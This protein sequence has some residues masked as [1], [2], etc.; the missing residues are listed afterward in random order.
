LQAREVTP[1]FDEVASFIRLRLRR[2]ALLVFLTSLDDPVLAESFVRNMDMLC[3][4][5]LIL[6]NMLKP[7]FANP[8]FSQG[9]VTSVDEV[10]LQLAGHLQWNN[11]REMEKVLGRRGVQFALVNNEKLCVELVSQYLNVKQRQ[12]L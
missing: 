3:R 7:A 5:H 8:I 12:L 9:N 11:L 10:Y 2:R 1:D 4:Q 6:V